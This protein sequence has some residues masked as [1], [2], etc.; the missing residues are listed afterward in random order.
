MKTEGQ[1]SQIKGQLKLDDDF[2]CYTV[3]VANTIAVRTH[4]GQC[5][6]ARKAENFPGCTAM[7]KAAW[8]KDGG[9]QR[10]R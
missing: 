1:K 7:K 9:R 5:P 3:H 6:Q 10:E 4:T 8:A 2:L